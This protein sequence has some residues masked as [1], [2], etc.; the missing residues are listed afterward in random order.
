MLKTMHVNCFQGGKQHVRIVSS[1]CLKG[2]Q[3]VFNTRIHQHLNIPL[4]DMPLTFIF[5]AVR[6]RLLFE[7]YKTCY[8]KIPWFLIVL[9]V[10]T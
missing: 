3:F 2:V 10:A 9:T 6:R 1:I 5:N 7:D 8:I 4:N